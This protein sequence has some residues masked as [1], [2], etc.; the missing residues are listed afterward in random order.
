MIPKKITLKN[1]RSLSD[2][3]YRYSSGITG[4]KGPNY[5]GKSNFAIIGQKFAWT[6]I[7]PT[8]LNKKDLLNWYE[9][10]GHSEFEFVHDKNVYILTRN[11]HNG[12][13]YLRCKDTD[14]SWTDSQEVQ[15]KLEEMVG[16]PM[17]LIGDFC[18]IP[19]FK[20]T[21]ILEM[22]R[23]SR[24]DYFLKLVGGDKADKIR[25][26]LQ[27]IINR[28]PVYQ[29]KS[30]E[31]ANN[32]QELEEVVTEIQRLDKQKADLETDIKNNK[33]KVED[34]DKF[35]QLPTQKEI[36]TQIK[37]KQTELKKIKD[38]Y[39][40]YL[41][42]NSL[43]PVG[44][45]EPL[46]EEEKK[47]REYINVVKPAMQIV[48]QELNNLQEPD[49]VENPESMYQM[50]LELKQTYQLEKKKLKH[51]EEGVC[52]ECERPFDNVTEESLKKKKQELENLKNSFERKK[53]EY[54]N[55][56]EAYDAFQKAVEQYN[57]KSNALHDK[58][59]DLRNFIPENTNYDI[60]VIEN[61][62]EQYK[63]Y[64]AYLTE[65]DK[66]RK[67]IN[68]FE[69]RKTLLE[70]DIQQLQEKDTITERDQVEYRKVLEENSNLKKQLDDLILKLERLFERKDNFKTNLYKLQEEQKKC[71]KNEEF[72]KFIQQ[73][74]DVFHKD[75][76]PSMV[77]EDRRQTLNYY[78]ADY[79]EHINSGFTAY[80]D[81]EFDF[82]VNFENGASER[83]VKDLSGGQKI[84][85][86][87]IFHLTKLKLLP[88]VPFLI[89]DEPTMYLNRSVISDISRIFEKFY[90][91]CQSGGS[92][93]Y[94]MI[95]TH[96]HE[97]D[98]C[99]TQIYNFGG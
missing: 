27:S 72:I 63:K 59:Q 75:N 3:V 12:K 32:E 98:S 92:P 19:Q 69:K 77:L 8:G 44:A 71:A 53:Q 15:D 40:T 66:R 95:P 17:D 80:I 48:E 9:K 56:K 35:L 52:P 21:S 28:V 91:D 88:Q 7:V 74:R 62:Q 93:V 41:D 14:E 13:L 90:R 79:F 82:R 25:K 18:F 46:T 96:E 58:L 31:I 20:L 73:T 81:D 16:I 51:Y 60:N 23:S 55:K 50:L 43:I 68:D 5:S 84:M 86:S 97:L 39:A 37:E 6:G 94:I 78:I 36:D 11:V 64:Q 57:S 99:F 24:M 33:N 4:V 34:A 54:A 49:T 22:T 1:V 30:E 67:E 83:P 87:V 10:K 47:Y 70:R 65:Y 26:R 29:D 76:L 38:E 42:D 45:C 61:K 85:L 89:L 2:F